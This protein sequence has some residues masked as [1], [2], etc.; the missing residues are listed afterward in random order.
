VR[1]TCRKLVDALKVNP[2]DGEAINM[3]TRMDALF[4]VDR[5]HSTQVVAF[6]KPA[7]LPPVSAVESRR[8]GVPVK[9]SL[10]AILPGLSRR[11]LPEVRLLTPAAPRPIAELLRLG[12]L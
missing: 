8:R 9:E 3:V 12:G 4:L 7:V 10:S 11:R 1:A 5:E 2:R 6:V